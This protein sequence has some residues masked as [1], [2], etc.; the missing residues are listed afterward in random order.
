MTTW[1]GKDKV[2]FLKVDG[3]LV[4]ALTRLYGVPYYPYFVYIAPHNDGEVKSIFNKT[5]RDY[6]NFKTWMLESLRNE[7]ETT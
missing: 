3:N 1:F 6:D 4:P 2:T 5:P 7:G